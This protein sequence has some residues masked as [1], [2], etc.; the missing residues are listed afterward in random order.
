MDPVELWRRT[1]T[2]PATVRATVG[3]LVFLSLPPPWKTASVRRVAGWAPREGDVL[4]AAG[5]E[6]HRLAESGRRGFRVLL[7]KPKGEPAPLV[8][9]DAAAVKL[10]DEAPLSRPA[11]L[12]ALARHHLLARP[13]L[14]FLGSSSYG[15]SPVGLLIRKHAAGV[16]SRGFVHYDW[17]WANDT[18]DP[19]RDLAALVERPHAFRLREL[20]GEQLTYEV[21]GHPEP[22]TVHV[23]AG[24]LSE[25]AASMNTW[26]DELCAERRLFEWDTQMD[27]I[28]FLGRAPGE[29]V[30]LAGEVPVGELSRA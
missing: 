4:E 1:T 19:V 2:L 26:L 23:E 13:S 7:V 29:V 16:P 8:V 11:W 6:D 22:I 9:G 24:D 20:C 10:V 14:W 21:V 25:L 27:R 18:N 30:A 3:D 28:A 17:R 5:R 12:E 15:L